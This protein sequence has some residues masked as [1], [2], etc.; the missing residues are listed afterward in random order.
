M[1]L[2][3]FGKTSQTGDNTATT[4]IQAVKPNRHTLAI[5][6]PTTCSTKQN[7]TGI[8]ILSLLNAYHGITAYDGLRDVI[9]HPLG[10]YVRRLVSVVETRPP[11]ALTTG[12]AVSLTNIQGA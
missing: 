1:K 12:L 11:F 7:T 2:K 10:K 6:M 4:K 5:F 8:N 3:P 9:Q